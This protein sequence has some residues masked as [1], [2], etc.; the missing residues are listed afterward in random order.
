MSLD[1]NIYSSQ[2]SKEPVF[3]ISCLELAAKSPVIRNLLLGLNI[4]DV[5]MC[6]AVSIIFADEDKHTVESAMSQMTHFRKSNSLSII[7][8]I[9]STY[10][11]SHY[12]AYFKITLIL[13]ILLD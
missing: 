10:F 11:E 6:P 12:F 1:V 2:Q 3:T 13:L 4:C 7:Q 5:S 8:G 9:E